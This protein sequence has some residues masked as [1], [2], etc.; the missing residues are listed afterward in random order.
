[1][2]GHLYRIGATALPITALRKRYTF[3]L[4][5][6][7]LG[8]GS[9]FVGTGLGIGKATL[10]GLAEDH[11]LTLDEVEEAAAPPPAPPAAPPTGP[12]P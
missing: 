2:S 12:N 5:D 3:R 8:V 9:A 11:G 10:Q 6:F 1:M 4:A 7:G